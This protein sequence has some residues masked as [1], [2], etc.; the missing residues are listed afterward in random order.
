MPETVGASPALPPM[1]KGREK[2]LSAKI[3]R[4]PLISLDSDD[5]IQGNPRK[6]NTPWRAFSQ[7]K[8]HAPRKSKQTGRT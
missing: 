2:F 3:L 6:S 1:A 5:R 7:Q 8:G 4:N